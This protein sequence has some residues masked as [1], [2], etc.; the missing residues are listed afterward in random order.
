MRATVTAEAY[1]SG[2][3]ETLRRALA[4]IG[5][6]DARPADFAGIRELAV[7][8]IS[9][10]VASQDS[11]AALHRR[12]GYGTY[13][14]RAEGVVTGFLSFIFLNAAGLR[15]V[16]QDVFTP[17][18][19]Q[20]EYVVEA[21]ETPVAVYCW[22]IAASRRRAAAILVEGSWSAR[23]ALPDTPYF[24]RAATDDGRRLLTLSMP[25]VAYPG[26]TT[27][28]LWWPRY[29]DGRRVAA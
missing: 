11:L 14:V 3:A 7:R 10:N 25:F 5:M 29:E 9:P 28:L 12:T 17:L 23:A 13:V 22:G 1:P 21:D 4:P 27:G 24:V 26:T 20:L 8:L 15:A 6:L 18:D 16:E 19:P 2:N